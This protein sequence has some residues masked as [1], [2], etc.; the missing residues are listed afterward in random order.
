MHPLAVLTG[1]VLGTAVSIT[2]SMAVVG[3]LFWL[4]APKYPQL[5]PEIRPLL[6]ASGLFLSLTAA[7]G[8]SFISLLRRAW[9]RWPAQAAMWALVALVVFYFLP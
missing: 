2:F 7:S 8:L 5:Q 3:L 1:F 6:V 4:L 9:W